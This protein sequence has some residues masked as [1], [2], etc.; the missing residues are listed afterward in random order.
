MLCHKIDCIKR[1]V[2]VENQFNVV[3]PNHEVLPEKFHH[4][5]RS[6]KGAS[7]G[8]KPFRVTDFSFHFTKRYQFQRG[9]LIPRKDENIHVFA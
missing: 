2:Y 8:W 7:V 9:I 1:S 4:Q 6:Q 5:G 3:S